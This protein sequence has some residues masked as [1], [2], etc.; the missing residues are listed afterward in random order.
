M[1]MEID[2]TTCNPAYSRARD[3]NNNG[4]LM[5]SPDNLNA[6]GS[7]ANLHMM[8]SSETNLNHHN[9]HQMNL[10]HNPL[11]HSHLQGQHGQAY[12]A[13]AICPSMMHG[14]NSQIPHLHHQQ[15]I[16]SSG[17]SDL[18]STPSPQPD[19]AYKLS[20]SQNEP[21]YKRETIDSDNY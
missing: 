1:N 9:H 11:S 21:I 19:G 13:H 8:N 14:S 17:Q 2:S 10:N 16:C 7:N 12:N 6:N 18:E 20:P 4:L 3:Q 15:D 5:C